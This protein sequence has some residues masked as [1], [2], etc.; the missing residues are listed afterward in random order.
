[1]DENREKAFQFELIYLMDTDVAKIFAELIEGL[2]LDSLCQTRL[3]AGPDIRG[4]YR[5]L[6]KTE[7]EC[8]DFIETFT[9]LTFRKISSCFLFL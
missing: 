9:S 7:I 6:H 3:L 5:G 4:R 2:M 1:M 8:T